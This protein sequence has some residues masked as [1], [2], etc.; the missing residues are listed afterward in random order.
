MEAHR[1]TSPITTS[2]DPMTAMTSA[3]MPPMIAFGSAWHWARPGD[4]YCGSIGDAGR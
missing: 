3:I 2:V 4:G 1:S